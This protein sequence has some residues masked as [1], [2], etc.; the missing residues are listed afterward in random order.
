MPKRLGVLDLT[1][2]L[3][4][5]WVPLPTAAGQVSVLTQHNDNGRTGANLNETSLTTSNVNVAQFGKLFSRLVDGQIY[6]QPLVVSNVNMPN[7]GILNVVYV[8]TMTNN[9]YAFDAENPNASAP[10]WRVNLGPSVP[11]QDTGCCCSDIDPVVGITGTPVIDFDPV[12]G[13]GTIYLVAKSKV[14][15]NYFQNLHAL[16]ITTG[17]PRPGSPVRIQAT[18]NGTGAGSSGGLLSFNPLKQLNRAGLLLLNGV[19]YIAFGSHCDAHPYHGWVFGYNATTLA[20]MSVFNTTPSGGG[21]GVWQSGQ[22]LVADANGDIYFMTGNGSFNANTGGTSYGESFVKLMTPGLTVSDYFTPKNF[23]SLNSGDLDLGSAGPLLLPDTTLLAGGGKQG[24]FYLVDSN[25]MGHFNAANDQVVQHFQA[26]SRAIHGSPIYWNSPNGGP[27]V[28]LWGDGDRLKAFKFFNGTFQTSPVA[29]GTVQL[30]G[31]VGPHSVVGAILSL[32][33]NGNTA[34]SGI[35][36]ATHSNDGDANNVTVPGVLR[37]FD[38]STVSN[39]LWNS[40]QNL[41]RDDLG[42]FAK[43]CPPTVA[44][45]KVY[46]ATFSN[47]LVV[48]GLLGGTP[49]P[50]DTQAPSVPTSLG[51]TTTSSTSVTLGWM[52]STDNVG[53]MAYQIFRG[54]TLVGTTSSTSYTDQGLTPCVNYSYTVKAYDGAGN[55]S[56]ASNLVSATSTS[57]GG[58]AC[59]S[60]VGSLATPVGPINLTSEGIRDWAHWGLNSSI[61]FD[62]KGGVGQQISN[63]TP[64]GTTSVKTLANNPTAFTWSDGT[65]T[66]SATNTKTGVFVV[67]LNKGFQIA[68]PADTTSRTLRIYVGLWKAQGKLEAT[69]SDGITPAYADTSLDGTSGTKN[70]VY[71]VNYRAASDGQT[72]TIKYTATKIY[73]PSGNVT[74][75]AA[76]LANVGSDTQAPSAPTNLGVTTTSSTSV[77]LSWTVSTD[78]VGV[79]GYQIFRGTTLAGISSTTNYTDN[80]LT[81]GANYN[82]TVKAYDGAGNVSVATNSVNATTTSSG[83]GSGGSLVGS[84]ATPVSP[85]NLTTEGTRDWAHWGLDTTVSFD[86]KSGVGQQIENFTPLG[87]ISVKRLVDNPTAFTWSDGTPVANAT[88][89]K[90]GVFVIGLNRGFQITLPADTTNRTLRIYVGLWKAQGKLEVTLSD[91][92]TQA[93]TNTSLDG[94]SGTKNGVYTLNYRAASSGQ[95]LTI[96]YTATK[97]YDPSGNVTLEA[98]TLQ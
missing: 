6:A 41:A 68:V 10:L 88:S 14:D 5:F 44:N 96:K 11:W 64:L 95:T 77:T 25:L 8:A 34:G 51:V 36:W 31:V 46:L 65:P 19:V 17:Y 78:N 45:G 89:T 15:N 84:L 82:Y 87:T 23:S 42:N 92:S 7:Q 35:V 37:A 57:S 58:G 9:V 72:L 67:G 33:A 71:T 80:G 54:A 83:G 32:S 55:V 91:G 76:T 39:E 70:G 85:I 12:S 22:G 56:G 94:T 90:T 1:L 48:Y 16:D 40:K 28:Y 43:F 63:Y 62:H 18:M 4:A 30:S 26:T 86:H 59:G 2:L 66:I 61:S 29:T 69:L 3:L 50:M 13:S 20:R 49:S 47:Q 24:T 93:Y 75:E 98:A 79:T 73:D 52:A 38:A 21:S 53:V 60:L 81:P 74:L 97:T 27:L